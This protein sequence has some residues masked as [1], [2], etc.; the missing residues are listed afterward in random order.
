MDADFQCLHCLFSRHGRFFRHIFRSIHHFMLDDRAVCANPDIHR[1][2]VRACFL[3]EDACRSLCFQKVLCYD[4][5]H[6]LSALRHAFFHHTV[7]GTHNHQ[8]FFLQIHPRISRHA[9]DTN[10]GVLQPSQTV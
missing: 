3:T 5:R 9:G 7:I 2:D 1:E 8:C 10:D 6:F 4:L